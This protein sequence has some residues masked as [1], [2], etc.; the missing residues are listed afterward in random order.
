MRTL[1]TMLFALGA[2]LLAS[3]CMP[4]NLS[5]E[6]KSRISECLRDCPD[7]PSRE[8]IVAG[9]DDIRTTCEKRC[10]EVCKD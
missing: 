6:C 5:E 2:L 8:A 9:S 10:H 3:A 4:I 1:G 7:P